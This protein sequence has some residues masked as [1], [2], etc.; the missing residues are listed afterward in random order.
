M[1]HVKVIQKGSIADEVQQIEEG[2]A[3]RAYELF[4]RRGSPPGDSW[5]DWFSRW[6]ADVGGVSGAALGWGPSAA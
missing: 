3:R 1:S 4:E 5:A 6:D 2:V